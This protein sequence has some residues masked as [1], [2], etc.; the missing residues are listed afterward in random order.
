M[1]MPIISSLGT[2]LFVRS[3]FELFSCSR[4]TAGVAYPLQAALS[5][6]HRQWQGG[7]TYE[8]ILA[9]TL[10]GPSKRRPTR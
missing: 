7:F 6:S 10:P 9:I 1:Q 3:I 5:D 2:F 4:P 8:Y